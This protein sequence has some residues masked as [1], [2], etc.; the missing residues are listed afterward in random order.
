MVP[1]ASVLMLRHS[2]SPPKPW[3][4]PILFSQSPFS[5]ICPGR[6]WPF[7]LQSL[8]RINTSRLRDGKS[9][10]LK[11]PTMAESGGGGGAHVQSPRAGTDADYAAVTLGGRLLERAVSTRATFSL[12]EIETEG[13][14]TL[15]MICIMP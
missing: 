6:G 5:L 7:C 9:P 12:L 3:W 1:G 14:L 11:H 15:H 10:R 4:Y 8:T 13:F 2:P